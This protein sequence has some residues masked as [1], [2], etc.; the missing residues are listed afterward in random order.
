MGSTLTQQVVPQYIIGTLPL[1]QFFCQ[2]T[3]SERIFNTVFFQHRYI[4]QPTVMPE[5]QIVKAVGNLT[6]ALQQRINARGWEEMEVC[7]CVLVLWL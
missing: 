1:P 4:T 2:K 6:S 7:V 5:D 3:H